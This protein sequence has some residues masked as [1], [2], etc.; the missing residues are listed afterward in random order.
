MC[1]LTFESQP[2]SPKSALKQFVRAFTRASGGKEQWAWIM[3]WQQRGVIHFH[4]FFSQSFIS[5]VGYWTERKE[6][7]GK[8]TEIIRGPLDEWI[9]AEWIKAT[10]CNSAKFR[11][12]Q[13]GGIVELLRSPDAAGR[14]VAKEAGKRTQKRLPPGV[15]A[16]GRWW[17]ISPAG[18]PIA[19]REIT[20]ER[21][22]FEKAY[23]HVF[24]VAELQRATFRERPLTII[25]NDHP[26]S[27][28]V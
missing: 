27:L 4:L 15:T 11:R 10:G 28:R 8:T 12:F 7:H 21:W 9:Q 6:R 13:A 17:W 14:Y 20:M 5:R 1:V 25:R 24:D 16:A 22:P 26:C 3:E 2:S 19:T 18:K 23:H